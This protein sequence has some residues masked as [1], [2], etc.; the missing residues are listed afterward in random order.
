MRRWGLD[1][2]LI[3]WV[4]CSCLA[5]THDR[6]NTTLSLPYFF[7]CRLQQTVGRLLVARPNRDGNIFTRLQCDTC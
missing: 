1:F 6:H 2:V 3:L 4:H 5:D 7:G